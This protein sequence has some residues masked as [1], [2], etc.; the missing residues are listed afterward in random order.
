MHKFARTVLVL[1][2][3]SALGW[4][5]AIAFRPPLPADGIHTGP[6]IERM[7]ELSQLLT[8]RIDVADVLVTRIDGV[9]GGV[10][11]AMLVKG[12]AALGIDLSLA[13][14]DQV[15]HAHCTALLILPP[16]Q[17]SCARVDHDRSRLFALTADGLWAITPGTRD[18]L[19]VVDKA[20]AQAQDLVASAAHSG[21][22]DERARRHAE[23][24]LGVFFRSIGWNVNIRWSD[25]TPSRTE[26][27]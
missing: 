6:S 14:F 11:V 16:P 2:I 21:D 26:P 23:L 24:L 18:Y 3:G 1:L 5:G 20:M 25:E 15:D 22:A 12:D 17:A 8:L 27:R 19:A 10:Q 7:S 9:T 4:A 13:R